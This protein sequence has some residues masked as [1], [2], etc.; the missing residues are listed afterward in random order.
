MISKNAFMM[1]KKC[2]SISIK[3]WFATKSLVTNVYTQVLAA[4]KNLQYP[5]KNSLSL[6]IMFGASWD[7]QIDGAKQFTYKYLHSILEKLALN[8]AYQSNVP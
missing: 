6:M 5:P 4:K 1:M 2:M 3:P 7:F 8:L